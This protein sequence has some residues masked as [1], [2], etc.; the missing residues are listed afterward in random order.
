MKINRLITEDELPD[1]LKN[2]VDEVEKTLEKDED[3]G[4]GHRQRKDIDY[5]D[6]L[7]EKEFLQALE[8]GNLDDA[9][10]QKRVRKQ[11]RKSNTTDDAELDLDENEARS[12]FHHPYHFRKQQHKIDNLYY[13]QYHQNVVVLNNVYK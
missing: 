2:N 12:S 9:V 5:S 11:N 1:W 3:L 7:T 4:K 10:E 8:E 13:H 6:H